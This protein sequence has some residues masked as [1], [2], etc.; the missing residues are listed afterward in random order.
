MLLLLT[1][2]GHW[3]LREPVLIVDAVSAISMFKGDWLVLETSRTQSNIFN[4][5]CIKLLPS[6]FYAGTEHY[7]YASRLYTGQKISN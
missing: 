5:F 3:C 2:R 6:P 1:F 4:T 7:A